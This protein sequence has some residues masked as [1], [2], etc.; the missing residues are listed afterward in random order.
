M[1]QTWLPSQFH[2][3]TPMPRHRPMTRFLRA[4]RRSDGAAS[5]VVGFLAS[6][7]VFGLVFGVFLTAQRE[8]PAAAANNEQDLRAVA[9]NALA[10]MLQ[11]PGLNDQGMDTWSEDPDKLQRF[12]L[13]KLGAPNFLDPAKVTALRGAADESDL[14]NGYPDYEEVKAALG[15]EGYEFH[16][17]SYPLLRS[18]D[19]P[20]WRPY[21]GLN[22]AY[23]AA[24]GAPSGQGTLA[25]S[26]TSASDRL[27][28]NAQITNTGDVDM[29]Y[30]VHF[31]LKVP[32]PGDRD[33]E[34]IQYTPLLA[35][36]Q[37]LTVS[38]PYYRLPD[39]PLG[40]YDIFLELRDS[41]QNKLAETTLTGLALPEGGST[42]YNLI[43]SPSAHKYVVG[44]NV[45]FSVD[46]YTANGKRLNT[47]PTVILN[48]TDSSG[49]TVL[50][51]NLTLDKSRASTVPC[52]ACTLP[53][54]YTATL[55]TSTGERPVTDRFTLLASNPFT[56]L[57]S[58]IPEALAEA[59]AVEN[60]SAT[61]NNSVYNNVTNP[62]GDVY[63]DRYDAVIMA[64]RL[65]EYQVLV[66]GSKVRQ[67]SLTPN[68][69]KEAIAAWVEDRG[70]TLIVFGTDDPNQQWMRP[71][72][73]TGI[74]NANGGIGAPDPT[75]PLLH[76]PEGLRYTE[77]RDHQ[78]AWS[79]RDDGFFSHVLRQP[80]VGQG[81]PLDVLAVSAPG[82]AG[83]GT[84]LLTSFTPGDL[85][86][87]Q[88][89]LEARKFLHNLF[90][91][92]YNVLYIDFGPP[93]P[94]K[95]QVASSTRLA[96]ISYPGL[97]SAQVE[98]K[99][100]LYVFR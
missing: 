28:V 21:T 94:S 3:V 100:V 54:T 97:P 71:I 14:N 52:P 32:T 62:G 83:N 48:V 51:G 76:A 86:S 80:S 9:E 77:Y 15:L 19:D 78:L 69:V 43:V 82:A 61:F 53:G 38:V 64:E 7:L 84:V 81:D 89:E 50:Y 75:H 5:P 91:Q 47:P 72:Y 24:Y 31:L 57:T 42:G 16:L 22:V 11:E 39:W 36:G 37:T 65:N 30:R 56:A 33:V 60:L 99:V 46:H 58:P 27:T 95:A 59:R 20:L 79:V 88:D 35:P 41:Y 98:M 68:F 70:G 90:A 96:V 2:K 29:V 93:I 25:T 73:E 55:T 18:I 85:T 12:G 66:I 40:G 44:D 1:A 49:S 92:A 74:H 87:P 63:R 13:A 10:I 67:S 8:A 4:L 34:D 45:S 17:R 26:T 6:M 23:L